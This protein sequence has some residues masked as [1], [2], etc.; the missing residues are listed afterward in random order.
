MGV[1]SL[2]ETYTLLW[3][4]QQYNA[5][6]TLLK[7]TGL[8]FLPFL[9]ILLNAFLETSTTQDPGESSFAALKSV[10]IDCV[11][12]LTVLILAAE[13][14]IP[15]HMEKMKYVKLCEG[16][17]V[18]SEDLTFNKEA[19]KTDKAFTHLDT[20]FKT[21]KLPVWW[22]G[23]LSFSHG[24]VHAGQ[25]AIPCV[26]DIA[27][28][29]IAIQ[30]QVIDDP[31]LVQ[32]LVKFIEKCY[33]PA[34]SEYQK[35]NSQEEF[36]THEN[37]NRM[38]SIYGK[39]DTEWPGS[40]LFLT[41]PRF[42]EN[43]MVDIS[44][45]SPN[46]SLKWSIN[47]WRQHAL[48]QE[49]VSEVEVRE[50][51]EGK[52]ISCKAIWLGLR[53]ILLERYAPPKYRDQASLF[54]FTHE[55]FKP[56]PLVYIPHLTESEEE[57][58][59][60]EAAVKQHYGYGNAG[61]EHLGRNHLN[62]LAAIERIKHQ[63]KKNGCSDPTQEEVFWAV[64]DEFLRTL[65]GGGESPYAS[66][67]QSEKGWTKNLAELGKWLSSLKEGPTLQIVRDM[68]PPIGAFTLMGITL[69]L[70]LG[71]VF[72]GYSVKF[73]MLGALALFTVK[74]WFYLWHLAWWL[75]QNLWSLLDISPLYAEPSSAEQTIWLAS[76]VL[77]A[78]LPLLFSSMV[79]WAGVHLI[80][81]V[82]G[83]MEG[84]GASL[85]KG[86]GDP[87]QDLPGW[88]VKRGAGVIT[89]EMERARRERQKERMG[90]LEQEVDDAKQY[91]YFVEQDL[92]DTERDLKKAQRQ[93][94]RTERA[95]D[96]TQQD[97]Y[98]R[99]QDLQNDLASAQK[100]LQEAKEKIEEFQRRVKRSL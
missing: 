45:L 61:L 54:S 46:A 74:F 34:R 65:V 93:L 26:R 73:L 85:K 69:L 49:K 79:G 52:R 36:H 38:W 3:G 60:R 92:D 27:R 37:V 86:A 56:K 57:T 100:A 89:Q 83:A 35:T 6:W 80:G 17:Q 24:L 5:I 88:M 25:R 58:Q 72:S 42:Y 15:V 99:E 19:G 87:G 97:D 64:Q 82:A 70:P 62:V 95:L 50:A 43:T 39:G 30:T 81:H 8:A 31:N 4:W 78:A 13:P 98:F 11:V 44:Y 2:F 76:T 66:L 20:A 9:G 94:K 51:L 1:D 96:D 67:V 40:Q 29:R 55:E 47:F 41:V 12:A 22:Y 28:E 23:V 91:S 16:G 59:K 84:M 63:I 77:Y 7:E 48:G 53:S 18:I 33:I 14:L 10:E 21:V 32:V 90:R 71:L 75:E 68:V